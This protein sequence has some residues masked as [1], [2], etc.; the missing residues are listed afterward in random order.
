MICGD[1]GNNLTAFGNI[2]LRIG[3]S[4]T[5]LFLQAATHQTLS[6][7]YCLQYPKNT[8]ISE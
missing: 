7:I 2:G 6:K 1:F 8:A 3:V 5:A 4:R